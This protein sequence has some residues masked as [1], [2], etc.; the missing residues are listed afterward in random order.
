MAMRSISPQQIDEV[1]NSLSQVLALIS[2]GR[3]GAL[4]RQD[5]R[6]GDD[7]TALGSVD[8][9]LHRQPYKTTHVSESRDQPKRIRASQNSGPLPHVLRPPKKT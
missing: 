8:V 1:N 3:S 9:C 2:D 6:F 7:S 5:T 4:E